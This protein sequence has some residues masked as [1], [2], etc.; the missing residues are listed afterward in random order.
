M[1][2]YVE[3]QGFRVQ[4]RATD[5]EGKTWQGEVTGTAAKHGKIGG[6][7]MNYIMESVYGSG[8]GLFQDY[9]DTAAVASAA[10][11]GN[12]DTKI[13]NL[14]KSNSKYIIKTG[15]VVDIDLIKEMRPQWK[16]AKYLGLVVTDVLMNGSK[17]ERDELS[18]RIY[19][20]ATSASDNSAPYIKVS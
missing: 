13:L 17:T 3:G 6:G 19:L 20:Y 8:K 1:D 4:F 11:M 14:A 9:S 18:T 5:A 16:F 7:V 2:I 10:Q 12:L 15:E